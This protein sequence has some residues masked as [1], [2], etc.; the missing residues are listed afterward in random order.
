MAEPN[1]FAG[2][3]PSPD[4][5]TARRELEF[6]EQSK[7]QSFWAQEA[8]R[9]GLKAR[10]EAMRQGI[11]MGPED[12]RAIAAQNIMAG[13]QKRLADLVRSGTVDPLDAQ[14]VAISE[15]KSALQKYRSELAPLFER[16]ARGMT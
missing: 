5:L 10:Q 16:V 14:E 7:G 13:A 3:I 6:A 11:A 9:S 15:A 12:A 4:N 2:L 1:P 8:G